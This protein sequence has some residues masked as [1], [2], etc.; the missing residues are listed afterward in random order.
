MLSPGEFVI[1][2]SA[3][4]AIGADNLAAMN[5]GVAYR[6]TGSKKPEDL[7]W[8]Q[9]AMGYRKKNVLDRAGVNKDPNTLGRTLDLANIPKRLGVPE[10]G[11]FDGKFIAEGLRPY[12]SGPTG[13][14]LMDQRAAVQARRDAAAAPQTMASLPSYGGSMFLGQHR[15]DEGMDFTKPGEPFARGN[16]LVDDIHDFGVGAMRVPG[17]VA[18][19]GRAVGDAAFLKGNKYSID[20]YYKDNPVDP[21]GQKAKDNLEKW[22]LYDQGDP[23]TIPSWMT[24]A[25]HVDS[26]F[27][28]PQKLPSGPIPTTPSGVFRSPL[29]PA[30]QGIALGNYVESGRAA[31]D[32]KWAADAHVEG[33]NLA[34]DKGMNLAADLYLDDA[35]GLSVPPAA[36]VGMNW[37]TGANIGGF[38]G[39][40]RHRRERGER[41]ERGE[42]GT[43]VGGRGLENIS[44][45][46][47][48]LKRREFSEEMD[49]AFKS[50][51]K[52]RD[53]RYAKANSGTFMDPE[54]DA[55]YEEHNR[56]QNEMY[57]QNKIK[58]GYYEQDSPTERATYIKGT[59]EIAREKYVAKQKEEHKAFMKRMNDMLEPGR[60]DDAAESEQE[61][62]EQMYRGGK[63]HDEVVSFLRYGDKGPSYTPEQQAAIDRSLGSFGGTDAGSDAIMK[64]AKFDDDGV[65]GDPATFK[66]DPV[67][68]KMLGPRAKKYSVGS[69]GRAAPWLGPTDQ[70]K[71]ARKTERDRQ[72][73]KR[74]E[75]KKRRQQREADRTQALKE[76]DKNGDKQGKLEYLRNERV[77]RRK[78]FN[79]RKAAREAKLLDKKDK[80][81]ESAASDSSPDR[82]SRF[83]SIE[84]R[85]ANRL[86][87]RE[88]LKESAAQQRMDR[89]KAAR[90]MLTGESASTENMTALNY[91]RI[92]R[93]QGT[94]AAARY[95]SRVGYEPPS[96][97]RFGQQGRRGQG[98]QRGLSTTE[99][100]L[101]QLLRQMTRGGNRGG[102]RNK[103]TGGGIGGG[104]DVIPA[105][106]TPGEF[107][108]SAGAVRQHGVG[109]MKALNRGQV[110]GFNRGGIVGGVQYREYGGGISG[111]LGGAAKAM[112][113]DTS[114]I[115]KV[116]DGFVGD[117]SST[118]DGITAIF[119]P[120]L[121]SISTLA[122]LFENADGWKMEHKHTGQINLT[123]AVKQSLSPESLEEIKQMIQ[124]K[125]EDKVDNEY[126]TP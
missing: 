68:G 58:R 32:A 87:S 63:S 38:G 115:T 28:K 110:P 97:M 74:A 1:R 99:E 41:G 2:K 62:I 72:A 91:Q 120:L 48:S 107:V 52:T 106:L 118:L 49:A 81:E 121:S 105:M 45:L 75:D 108:M 70:E 122:S 102:V 4:D 80:S 35:L 101:Q 27:G 55:A 77:Q 42:T 92:L 24:P 60:R 71:E 46:E 84:Q 14:E 57:E 33:F 79:E 26:A 18:D 20:Q 126:K 8:W 9:R 31:K 19:A 82:G 40:L 37:L 47:E 51:E 86:S 103:A 109:T 25:T 61:K 125:G 44:R 59:D 54:V 29:T 5:D 114:G 13:K 64:G 10:G 94:R 69:V 116:F 30:G 76:F 96:P 15:D 16:T 7:P 104:G 83:L 21:T 66:K 124:G 50:G 6:K 100:L 117:F 123:G 113:F 3:V 112:G 56:K 17:K 78:E 73:V 119:S 65:L 12:G 89:A 23:S 36:I 22:N 111:M 11:M 90:G 95:A 39:S 98:Q 43:M 53:A 34:K 67:T 93:T 88:K 85:R